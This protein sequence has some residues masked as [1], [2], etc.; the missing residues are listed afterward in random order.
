MILIKPSFE[1]L[2]IYT[3]D[4]LKLIER[5]GRTAYKSEDKIT[6][7]SA[8]RFVKMLR[9][10]GHESVLEHSC[11]TVKFIVDRGFLT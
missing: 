11:L 2:G 10:R 3:D 5:A 1:I 4:P 8:K 6:D 9:D 7:V